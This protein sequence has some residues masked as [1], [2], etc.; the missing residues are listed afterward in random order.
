[1]DALHEIYRKLVPGGVL[2]TI[3]NIEDCMILYAH[4]GLV[5]GLTY[6]IIRLQNGSPRPSG[7]VS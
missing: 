6:Q 7:R 5:K 4:S 1:M 3:W 2:G